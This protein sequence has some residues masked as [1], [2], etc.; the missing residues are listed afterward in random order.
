[1]PRTTKAARV[2]QFA[3]PCHDCE[4]FFRAASCGS[5]QSRIFPSLSIA[6]A[7][8]VSVTS[9]LSIDA[10]CAWYC[11]LSRSN[12]ASMTRL[13]TRA[14]SAERIHGVDRTNS[15]IPLSSR[16]SKDFQNEVHLRERIR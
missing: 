12:Q 9:K 16:P 13:A 1:M 14:R 4:D 3:A 11:R 7:G 15:S 10:R 5:R 2:R 6:R 8:S